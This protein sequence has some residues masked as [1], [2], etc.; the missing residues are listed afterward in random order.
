VSPP[1]GQSGAC[2]CGGWSAYWIGRQL[3]E[4][5]RVAQER[6]EVAIAQLILPKDLTAACVVGN[7]FLRIP[8]FDEF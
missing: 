2:L 1:V 6:P 5:L 4:S 8:L 3:A 7:E